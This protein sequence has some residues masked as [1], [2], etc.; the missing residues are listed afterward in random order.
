M[1]PLIGPSLGRG[2]LQAGGPTLAVLL[3]AL[4]MP[5]GASA[6][7]AQVQ[8]PPP[9]TERYRPDQQT[10]TPERQLAAYSNALLPYADQPPAVLERLRDL[11]RQLSARSL[12]SCL[13]QG[14]LSPEQVER[15]MAAMGMAVPAPEPEPKE[16][17]ALATPT[18][19]PL[20]PA[21]PKPAAP[22][23][24]DRSIIRSEAAKPATSRPRTGPSTSPGASGFDMSPIEWNPE[25]TKPINPRVQDDP[26]SPR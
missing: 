24:P 12:R 13:V 19:A 2:V 7:R 5:Q 6:Q 3:L 21:A 23:V 1:A 10:C 16:S 8:E 14:L 20:V 18:P 9:P 11:Q 15:L 25:R 26:S 17:P 22:A 4:A